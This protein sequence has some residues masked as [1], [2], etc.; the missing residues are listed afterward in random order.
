MKSLMAAAVG[1]QAICAMA[2]LIPMDYQ[3]VD[4]GAS[5]MKDAASGQ[6][7][8][9]QPDGGEN[10]WYGNIK[11]TLTGCTVPSSKD[12]N[13]DEQGNETTGAIDRICSCL[14]DLTVYSTAVVD[15]LLVLIE[16]QTQDGATMTGTCNTSIPDGGAC[17][18]GNYPGS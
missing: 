15:D 13:P 1:L 9:F 7:T 10:T 16:S 17:I 5:E 3:C 2:C 12:A 18:G 6:G 14:A 8:W 11:I 4:V